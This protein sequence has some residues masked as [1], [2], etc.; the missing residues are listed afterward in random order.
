MIVAKNERSIMQM[1]DL[2]S[3]RDRILM[4]KEKSLEMSAKE[5][6]MTAFHEAGHALVGYKMPEHDPIY[7]ISI[8]PRGRALGVTMYLPEADTYSHSRQ[9]LKSQ[10]V[11]L[12]G[13]RAA[14]EL[15]YGI[16]AVTTGASNDLERATELARS[17]VTK[18]G[19]SDTGLI[20]FRDRDYDMYSEDTKQKI[21]NQVRELLDWAYKK[22]YDLLK[23]NKKK[24]TE[25]ARALVEQETSDFDQ[26]RMLI[27]EENASK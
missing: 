16:D 25:V 27:G 26:F 6:E 2:D 8:V 20:S 5:K 9:Y 24:L 4:G 21:D 22:A 19:F 11:S 13:G 12:M 7:K 14:E 10:L 15:Q 3:A 1:S 18:W 17:M 23:R